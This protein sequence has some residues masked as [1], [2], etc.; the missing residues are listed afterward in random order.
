MLHQIH[1]SR[2]K[3][4]RAERC[5]AVH[6]TRP[7]DSGNNSTARLPSAIASSFRPNAARIRPML[8]VSCGIFRTLR[9]ASFSATR[10]AC[11]NSICAFGFIALIQMNA[12]LRES[13][14]HRGCRVS[15]SMISP[16][17]FSSDGER[18]WK[19]PLQH[20]KP[21]PRPG[22]QSDSDRILLESKQIVFRPR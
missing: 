11:S 6:Q 9:A 3:S 7:R 4:V 17:N 12:S 8:R 10:R 22:H 19:V 15:R 13:L 20:Q 16:R 1:R 21:T 2:H 18:F 14:W 5:F